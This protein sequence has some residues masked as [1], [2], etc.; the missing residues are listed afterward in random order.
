MKAMKKKAM[1]NASVKK[2]MKKNVKAMKGSA[3]KKKA[4]MKV[5]KKVIMKAQSMKTLK[6]KVWS[7]KSVPMIKLPGIPSGDW[8][9]MSPAQKKLV[10]KKVGDFGFKNQVGLERFL[11]ESLKVPCDFGLGWGY[12]PETPIEAVLRPAADKKSPIGATSFVR[13]KDHAVYLTTETHSDGSKHPVWAVSEYG[14]AGS[15]GIRKAFVD[16]SVFH[17]ASLRSK[18]KDAAFSYPEADA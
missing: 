1:K 11:V 7:E 14:T 17:K 15:I 4:P 8:K 2:V 9:K 10:A 5:M 12:R 3:M 18:Q 16:E 6:Q 13:P